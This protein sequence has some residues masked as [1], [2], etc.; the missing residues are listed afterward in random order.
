MAALPTPKPIPSGAK[1]GQTAGLDVMQTAHPGWP[2]LQAW[3][4]QADASLDRDQ[5]VAIALSA[6]AD[7]MALLY[8]AA[9]VWPGRVHAIHVNHGLQAA[10]TDF[11]AVAQQ[12]C[13]SLALPLHVVRVQAQAQ[14]GESPEA[15]A[16]HARYVALAQTAQAIQAAVVLL[17]HHAQDQAETVL[18]ALSRGAGLPGLS[19]MAPAFERHGVCFARP[20][21]GVSGVVLRD[22]LHAQGI[23]YVQDPSNNEL[24][25]TRNRIRHQVL[26]AWR[27]AFDAADDMLARSARHAAQAQSLLEELAQHDWE[28]VGPS[29]RIQQL[30]TLSPARQANVLRYWLAQHHHTQASDA[31]LQA[32]LQQ[33]AACTTRGH[34]IELKVGHGFVVRNA[35]ALVFVQQRPSVVNDAKATDL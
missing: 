16:R 6:G 34:R 18:L 8:A 14:P 9:A 20:W 17:A 12:A 2:D 30:R 1:H 33:V 11:E 32:L 29:P 23:A 13:H 10:A 21:L 4:H 3:A 27:E 25:Y 5:P 28:L 24:H 19:G 31:Q 26:P 15:A 22:W 7:S 35:E